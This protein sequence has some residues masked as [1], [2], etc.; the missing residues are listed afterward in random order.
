MREL[1]R[2]EIKLSCERM[3]EKIETSSP[4]VAIT[5]TDERPS[6]VDP[7]PE[8]LDPLNTGALR[9]RKESMRRCYYVQSGKK[10]HLDRNC[11]DMSRPHEVVMPAA[12]S[13]FVAWCHRCAQDRI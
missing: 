11:C 13:Q 12:A 3:V 7:P 6:L 5:D 10:L 9:S 1:I 2:R 8:M 4:R